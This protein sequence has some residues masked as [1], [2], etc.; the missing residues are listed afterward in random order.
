VLVNHELSGVILGLTLQSKPE[1]I[2][3]ALLESTAYGTRMIVDTFG[4]SGVPVTEFIVI[5]GLKK[6]QLLMQIYAD[7]LGMP[8]SLVESTQG[9][10]LGSA[11]HAAVAAGAYPDVQAAADVMGGRIQNAYTPD[12]QNRVR[13]QALYSE[14]ATL[15]DYF[16]R[17]ANDV[18]RRLKKIRREVH[19]DE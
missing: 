15:H 2:Y 14:Y 12:P 4:A 19:G 8:L 17:G 6:N 11:I 3:R 10:A 16:G 1:D 13:Y 7:V 5:G 18:M 9:P